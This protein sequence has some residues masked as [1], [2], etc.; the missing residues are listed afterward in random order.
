MVYELGLDFNCIMACGVR[1]E[2]S[3]QLHRSSICW[4]IHLLFCSDRVKNAVFGEFDCGFEI[5]FYLLNIFL[6]SSFFFVLIEFWM[7]AWGGVK[8]RSSNYLR[9]G[10]M[11]SNERKNVSVRDLVEEAK[12]R[13]LLLVVCIVGLSYLM[14][15]KSLLV[16]PFLTLFRFW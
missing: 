3:V 2:Y 13:I 10:T 1:I 4:V 14:S 6:R 11:S 7:S 16:R 12:K 15:C 9:S 5:I 8:R